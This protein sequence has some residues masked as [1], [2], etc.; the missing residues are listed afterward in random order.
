MIRTIKTVWLGV[1]DECACHSLGVMSNDPTISRNV[2]RQNVSWY[3]EWERSEDNKDTSRTRSNVFSKMSFLC[4]QQADF[5]TLYVA[6]TR[7]HTH[8]Q[9]RHFCSHQACMGLR[10]FRGW[11]YVLKLYPWAPECTTSGVLG[12]LL[13]PTCPGWSGRQ[14]SVDPSPSA[15]KCCVM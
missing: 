11:V 13:T 10:W 1:C 5:G 7:A 9:N 4:W 8:T 3:P 14:E 2:D 12:W 15:E 6:S